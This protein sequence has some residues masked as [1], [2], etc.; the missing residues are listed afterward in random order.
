MLTPNIIPNHFFH[1]RFL[2]GSAQQEDLNDIENAAL[3]NA[4]YMA[5]S[6]HVQH[7]DM[8]GDERIFGSKRD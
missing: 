6:F 5:T 2:I 7:L 8:R 3:C 1:F 4:L